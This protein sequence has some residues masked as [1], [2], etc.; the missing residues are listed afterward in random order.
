M[1]GSKKSGGKV[2]NTRPRRP[3]VKK[4]GKGQSV[5]IPYI[6]PHLSVSG[7]QLT[8]SFSGPVVINGVLDLGVENVDFVSQTVVDSTTVVLLYND[9]LN[10]NS[11]AGFP[12]G[13]SPVA[14][15]NGSAFAGIDEGVFS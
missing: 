7:A 2:H 14:G 5:Q 10:T 6:F 11:Y 9:D 13:L 12:S 1:M 4:L 15:A 3:S 8:I